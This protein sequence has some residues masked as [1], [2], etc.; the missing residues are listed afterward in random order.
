MEKRVASITVLLFFFSVFAF[1]Q[2][3]E[4]NIR[5]HL[6]ALKDSYPQTPEKEIHEQAKEHLTSVSGL[7]LDGMVYGWNFVYTPSDKLRNVP[8]Y[9]ECTEIKSFKENEKDIIYEAPL[10]REDKIFFWV[11]FKRSD[12]MIRYYR[13]FHSVTTPE[14]IGHGKGKVSKGFPGLEEA[15]KNAVKNGVREYYR[16]IVKN[17]PKEISGSILIKDVP[18]I[19]IDSGNYVVELD[20]FLKT[21]RIKE[22]SQF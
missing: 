22:Y 14:V 5:L 4:K 9:F 18:A 13:L 15:A 10:F 6:W 16:K 12:E 21:S 19:Y 17:K 20:F 8:E 1:A 3:R 2:V 7:L 11:N